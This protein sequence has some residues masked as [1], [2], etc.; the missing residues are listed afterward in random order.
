MKY[1]KNTRTFF[2]CFKAN[3]ITSFLFK[4][5]NLKVLCYSKYELNRI[6]LH[7]N[8]DTFWT[9]Y[10]CNGCLQDIK[11]HLDISK[12]GIN[13]DKTD[14]CNILLS[15][16]LQYSYLLKRLTGYDRDDTRKFQ[17]WCVSEG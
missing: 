12:N 5:M 11:S 17:E 6:Y 16:L 4:Q 8:Y 3:Y 10:H 9:S 1:L 2:D 14:Y 13:S 15:L 7:T